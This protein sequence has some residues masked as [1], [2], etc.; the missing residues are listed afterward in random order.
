M[1]PV[2]HRSRNLVLCQLIFRFQLILFD[3]FYVLT[4]R[5]EDVAP[6]GHRSRNSVPV[7]ANFLFQFIQ[8]VKLV[9]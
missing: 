9:S 3:F 6:V 4:D 2:G 5:K 1:A 8:W 7:S